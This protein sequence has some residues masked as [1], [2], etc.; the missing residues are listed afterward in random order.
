[1]RRPLVAAALGAAAALS[2]VA[3]SGAGAEIFQEGNLRASFD[4]AISPKSLPRSHAAPVGVRVAG[5][6]RSL[7]G[8]R[9]PQLRTIRV[10]INE[11]GRLYDRG[12]PICRVARIQPATERVARQICGEA[13]VGDGK[14]ALLV[15]LS[16]QRDFLV[17]GKLLAF[18]GPRRGKKKLILAQI[19]SHN[20]PG[21]FI[22]TFTVTRRAGVYGT[23]I[24]TQLPAYARSWAYLTHFEMALRRTYRH[25]G[26]QRTYISAACAAPAGFRRIVF[27]FAKASYGFAD[28]RVLS[29]SITRICS[30]AG[31]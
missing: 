24:S 25:A 11:A 31:P 30:V 23:V 17:R 18:N 5:K 20:P 9:L 19:Y 26:R 8:A 7:G 15:R 14:V 1:M 3:P 4:G 29:T 16:G 12:L 28:G 21:S 27:P 13:I 2:G 6:V 10:A 22:L